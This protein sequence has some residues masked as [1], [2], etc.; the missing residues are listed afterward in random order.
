MSKGAKSISYLTTADV[1]CMNLFACVGNITEEQARS[2]GI[3]EYRFNTYLNMDKIERIRHHEGAFYRLTEEGRQ[4]AKDLTG[5]DFM[6]HSN[7]FLHDSMGL[8]PQ[9]VALSESEQST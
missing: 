2:S 9:F 1:D 7:A 8:F 5:H 3:T 4:F 6:Y